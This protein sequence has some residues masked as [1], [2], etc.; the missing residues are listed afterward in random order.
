[1]TGSISTAALQSQRPR[2]RTAREGRSLA[3][4]VPTIDKQSTLRFLCTRA[5]CLRASLTCD[6]TLPLC[7]SDLSEGLS[8]LRRN[9]S[10][11]RERAVYVALLFAM[12]LFLCTRASFLRD[13]LICDETLPLFAR[14]LST[15]LSYLRCNPSSVRERAVYVALIC[16]AT[17]TTILR[18][19]LLLDYLPRPGN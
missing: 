4:R 2:R 5:G 17:P 8:Y 9:P 14:G 16:D 19:Y 18:N 13:S 7:A 6:A 12:Q 3:R 15:W 11:V 1:M 10:S